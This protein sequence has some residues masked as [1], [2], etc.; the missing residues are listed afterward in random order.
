MA[1][2]PFQV[3]VFPFM[4][5]NN[6]DIVYAVF[7]RSDNGIWQAVAGGGEDDETAPEA[8]RREAA[9]EGGIHSDR[10][11]ELD[12]RFAVPAVEESGM[13]WGAE[14]L[15]LP[16]YCF[17]IEVT[18]KNLN[19]SDEHDIFRWLNYDDARTIL[20]WD[21]NKNA[22]WELNY[23]LRRFLEGSSENV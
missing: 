21:S 15:V 22:L 11:I 6:H 1:R 2:A 20:H 12:S 9:E 14:I 10:I 13:L 8:A 19:L 23:R 18:D 17:G 16:E 3:L 4:I 7:K 5:V